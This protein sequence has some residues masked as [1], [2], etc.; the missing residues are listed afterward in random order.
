[1]QITNKTFIGT[2]T[3]ALKEKRKEIF[4]FYLEPCK[5][6]KI[7]TKKL[8]EK[9]FSFNL[10]LTSWKIKKRN[11]PCGWTPVLEDEEKKQRQK[12]FHCKLIVVKFLYAYGK[13]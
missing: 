9:S 1:M 2:A 10:Q 11:D 3:K 13:D 6:S 8:D 5:I 7:K 12:L 4:L